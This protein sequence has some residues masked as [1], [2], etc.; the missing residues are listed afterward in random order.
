MLGMVAAAVGIDRT[1]EKQHRTLSDG[2][3]YAVRVDAVGRSLADYH[4][5]QAGQGRAATRARTRRM[6]LENPTATLL[7]KREYR[8]DALYTVVLWERSGS[9]WP[10]AVIEAAL[11]QPI[12]TLYVG[13]KACPL[14]LPLDPRIIEAD[15]L[16]GALAQRPALR[17]EI[18]D[19]LP[20]RLDAKPALFCDADAPGVEARTITSRRDLYAR[21]GVYRERQEKELSL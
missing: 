10:L 16:P 4:T 1:D 19:L 15:D 14:G 2:L 13:R 6:E 21:P 3:G 5:V 12:W 18:A 11:L 20:L 9:T 17:P 8:T 7:T